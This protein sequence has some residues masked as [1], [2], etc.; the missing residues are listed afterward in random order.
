MGWFLYDTDLRHERVNFITLEFS[1]IKCHVMI[2]VFQ[3]RKN[4]ALAFTGN[5][6]WEGKKCEGKEVQKKDFLT[7]FFIYDVNYF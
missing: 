3:V 5:I 1:D 6:L 2:L 7:S 4:N